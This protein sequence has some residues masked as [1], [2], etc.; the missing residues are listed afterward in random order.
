MEMYVFI[1]YD[2]IYV[3]LPFS[4]QQNTLTAHCVGFGEV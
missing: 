1:I 3:T 4:P 2:N